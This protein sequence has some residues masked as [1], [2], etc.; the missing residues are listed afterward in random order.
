MK[1]DLRLGETFIYLECQELIFKADGTTSTETRW[2][3]LVD[4][5]IVYPSPENLRFVNRCLNVG[6]ISEAFYNIQK[7]LKHNAKSST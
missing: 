5:T 4:Q 7:E 2:V 3:N 1:G 6:N